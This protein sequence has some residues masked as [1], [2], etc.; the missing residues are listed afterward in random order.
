MC[1]LLASITKWSR[2]EDSLEIKKISE[3]NEH[4]DIIKEQDH[5]LSIL[6]SE[7]VAYSTVERQ[8]QLITSPI[9][10]TVN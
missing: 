6:V 10:E 9:Y 8:Q 7:N 2:G 1:V 5:Q 3:Q 4:H